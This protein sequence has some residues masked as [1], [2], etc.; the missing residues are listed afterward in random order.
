MVGT[1]LKVPVIIGKLEIMTLDQIEK[2][3]ATWPDPWP[4]LVASYQRFRNYKLDHAADDEDRTNATEVYKRCL[5]KVIEANE[6]QGIEVRRYGSS[7]KS[8]RD[9]DR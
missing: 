4:E 7:A 6:A 3:I 9:A 2:T 5:L 8:L 1:M